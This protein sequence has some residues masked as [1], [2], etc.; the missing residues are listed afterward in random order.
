[1]A[2]DGVDVDILYPTLGLTLYKLDDAALQEASFHV[3]NEWIRDYC[4]AAAAP[5]YGIGMLSTYNIEKAI[6]ELEWCRDAGMPGA[7]VW[8]VPHPDLPFTSGHYDPLWDA[9][10]QLGMPISVHILTGFNY[11]AQRSKNDVESSRDSVNRKTAD[12]VDTLFDFIFTGVLDRFP[13]LKL[14]IVEGEIGWVP[15]MLQQ[16]DY[17]FDRFKKVRNL[18]IVPFRLNNTVRSLCLPIWPLV[19]PKST[20][21]SDK[22][23]KIFGYGIVSGPSTSLDLW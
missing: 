18:P 8:Q 3:Y 23:P 9:A 1:M 5:L 2:A 11:S 17:Y 15:F 19:P 20:N 13:K 7:M 16:W 10:Q 4:E 14:V 12:L 22:N 21:K 6:A